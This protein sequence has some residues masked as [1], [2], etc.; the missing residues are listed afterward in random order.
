VAPWPEIALRLN[1][2]MRGWAGYFSY[3]WC[4]KSYRGLDWYVVGKVRNFL[5][6][7]HKV[8]KRG[9]RRFSAG[10]IHRELGVLELKRLLRRSTS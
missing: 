10:H 7:R 4:W 9:T 3:G 5:Q 6:R 2:A 8:P 1:R